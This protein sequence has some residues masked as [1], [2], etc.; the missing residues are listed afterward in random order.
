MRNP[1]ATGPGCKCGLSA[2]GPFGLRARPT[3]SLPLHAAVVHRCLLAHHSMRLRGRQALQQHWPCR[4]CMPLSPLFEGLA[5]F[6]LRPRRAK[7]NNFLRGLQQPKQTCRTT[8]HAS[9]SQAS[10]ACLVVPA[11][12]VPGFNSLQQGVPARSAVE[13]VQSPVSGSPFAPRLPC[14]GL[15]FNSLWKS[16]ARIRKQV[17]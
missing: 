8:R 1:L 11:Q 6:Q 16:K 15:G 10:S 14:N 4:P 7:R 17:Q 12:P 2:S 5:S 13:R 9:S 3:H